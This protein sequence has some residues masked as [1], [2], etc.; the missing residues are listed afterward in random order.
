MFVYF[1][2]TGELT[3]GAGQ[4]F[5]IATYTVDDPRKVTKAFRKWQHT[6]FPKRLKMQTELKF[7]DSHI[8]DNL[9]LKTLRYFTKQNIQITYTYLKKKN[10]PHEYIKKGKVVHTGLLYTEIVKSTLELY[11]PVTDTQFTVIRDQRTL[12]GISI[13]RFNKSVKES[14]LSSLPVKINF[15]IQAVDST[16]Y[17]LIQVADWICGALARYYEHK[18]MGDE[19][20]SLLKGN[21]I[22][23]RELFSERSK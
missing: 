15:Q 6:K 21:I 5:L 7:N 13:E 1:D 8:D 19:F 14:L 2:E 9:R 10:I 23:A 17:P 18:P 20:Y 3:E 4:Y 16:T 22:H 12:K 11:L